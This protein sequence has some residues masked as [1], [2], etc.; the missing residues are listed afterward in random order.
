MSGRQRR[1]GKEL[2]EISKDPPEGM[3]VALVNDADINNWEITFNGPEDSPY[4]GGQFKLLL[5]LPTEYPFK[6]PSLSFKTKVYH[7]NV[8]ND[9]KGSMCLGMLRS[10]E[11]K[12][13]SKIA[14][15][16]GTARNL[17]VEPNPDDAVETQIA[18]QY[19][20]NRKEFDKVAREWTKRYAKTAS[21]GQA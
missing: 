17:M 5:A 6:P 13:S 1:I 12:P 11:W 19:K 15:L 9:D 14:G 10:E 4:A 16:L 18:E 8:S 2:A 20:T 3:K 21:L 7:P